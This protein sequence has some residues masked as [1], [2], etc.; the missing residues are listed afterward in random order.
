MYVGT[1][2]ELFSK[3][4]N[5]KGYIKSL[6]RKYIKGDVLEVGAGI[7][8][9]T[10]LF[11]SYQYTTWLCLEPDKKL[12][13]ALEYSIAL[14]NMTNYYAQN[15]TIELLN[16]K[17]LFDSILYIDVLE[18]IN[19]DKEELIKASKHLKAGGNLIILSPA[20]QW[21]FTPFDAAIGH[22]RRYN[23]Q[24]LKAI[25]PND[26]EVINFAYLDCVGLLAS[27]GNKLIL[28]QSKPT[29]KQVKLWDKFMVAISRRLD[30]LLGYRFGKSI[31][32]VGRKR[33]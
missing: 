13:H 19:D 10:R 32:L 18:H 24:T 5:W 9:N 6:L 7:G 1:E 31:L 33:C 23:K 25:L 15:G 11:C 12:F 16:G 20:H 14:F 27:L 4:K 2:L 26:I 8:N 29:S 3:A 30:S 17:Q 21:L 22:Y 28:R